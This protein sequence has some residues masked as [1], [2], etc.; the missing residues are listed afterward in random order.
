MSAISGNIYPDRQDRQPYELVREMW[1]SWAF[2]VRTYIISMIWPVTAM[3][4]AG[5]EEPD[6]LGFVLAM[7]GYANPSAAA[8][9][10]AE[11]L[12]G[13]IPNKVSYMGVEGSR[14]VVLVGPSH[15]VTG[16]SGQS[17]AG[18][19]L[20][21]QWTTIRT[22][23]PAKTGEYALEVVEVEEETS[24]AELLRTVVS[25]KLEAG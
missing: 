3:E 6:D 12:S 1:E 20:Q 9:L 22:K 5:C 23:L 14:V 16:S 21:E 11:L 25:Q 8:G 17:I 10:C 13:C 7:L 15:W 24:V 18:A 4:Y 19:K 2:N